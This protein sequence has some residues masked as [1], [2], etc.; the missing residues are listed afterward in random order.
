MTARHPRNSGRKALEAFLSTE[1]VGGV[2]LFAA[3][4]LALL[5]ENSPWHGA[6]EH[7]WEIQLVHVGWLVDIDVSVHFFV[8]EILMTL[9][10]FVVGLEI[11][12]EMHDGALSSLKLA[13]LPIAA[14][15][16]GV[17]V[18]ALLYLVIGGDSTHAGGWA[19]PTATDIA[20][21]VGVLALLGKRVPPALRALLLALAIADD[22]AAIVIIAA[23]FAGGVSLGGLEIAAAGVALALALR[24]LGVRAEIVYAL[25]AA[26]L[27]V[28]LLDAGIHP[29]LAGVIM[30][31]LTP[32]TPRRAGEPPAAVRIER[33]LHP[34]IAFLVMPLFAL[35]N[36][37]IRIGGIDLGD[38][39]LRTL[40]NAVAVG[41]IAGKPLGIVSTAWLAVRLGWCA[42]PPGV[43]LSGVLVIG[44]LGG[45]GF[46][47][48][49][50]IATL[51]FPDT[52]ALA[53]A[54]LAV[55]VGSA[56]AAVIGLTLGASLLRRPS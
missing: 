51:A 32:M 53:A 55:L 45:I 7:L 42:L 17:A 43:R 1:T 47:M 24:K 8:N 28:G 21:A 20:F 50:F 4:V 34:W 22:V 49:I 6:Y 44:C 35:A 29:V 46:T 12:R 31:L 3:T 14:A 19:V 2:V 41:L 11:R 40:V 36:A 16:G 39:A 15:A 54:K 48:A 25:P 18:P 37:G 56:A 10:F 30:G 26:V 52:A 23:V 27:W 13:A 9:F 5:W 33:L 38:P